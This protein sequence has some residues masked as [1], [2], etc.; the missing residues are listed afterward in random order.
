VGVQNKLEEAKVR[1]FLQ[2]TNIY[3]K[4]FFINFIKKLTKFAFLVTIFQLEFRQQIKHLCSSQ[5]NF[6]NTEQY[7][8][9][10]LCA[11]KFCSHS[12]MQKQHSKDIPI[13]FL[14]N[15]SC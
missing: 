9:Y 2:R 12:E 1:T 5:Q 15:K 4:L 3:S 14:V 7:T 11:V 10:L 6:H 13:F 8:Q